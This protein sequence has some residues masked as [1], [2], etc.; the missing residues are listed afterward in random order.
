MI[1]DRQTLY[2]TAPGPMEIRQE[3][4]PPPSE[5]RVVVRALASGISPGTEILFY[6]GQ[7][8]DSLLIDK[9]IAGM[10]QPVA[11]PLKYGYSMVGE[12]IALRP[13]GDLGWLVKRLFIF[14]PHQSHFL[15]STSELMVLPED[16]SIK[17][18]SFWP[19]W[20]RRSTWQWTAP[21]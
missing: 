10:N 21:H 14:H 2:F 5:G 1:V 9:S 4:L 7:V 16:I 6:R 20:K 17:M 15:A 13:Q 19:I 8:P 12:V 3:Q 11:Y 18:P